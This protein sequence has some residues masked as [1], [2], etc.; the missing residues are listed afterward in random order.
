[1]LV[2]I[3]ARK[4]RITMDSTGQSELLGSYRATLTKK[5]KNEFG[6]FCCAPL[7]LDQWCLVYRNALLWVV[8]GM[9]YGLWR[10]VCQMK[11]LKRYSLHRPRFLLVHQQWLHSNGET[12]AQESWACP[13]AWN[14][15]WKTWSGWNIRLK[16]GLGNFGKSLLFTRGSRCFECILGS[17]TWRVSWNWSSKAC[18]E[19]K[20]NFWGKTIRW[21]FWLARWDSMRREFSC[22][23]PFWNTS[24]NFTV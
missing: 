20:K 17:K 2:V 8:L 5:T 14:L 9:V 7:F 11:I 6:F 18:L 21:R 22:T 12:S 24:F 15:G 4:G 16:G 10:W 19:T 13:P 1:M 3:N 23:C